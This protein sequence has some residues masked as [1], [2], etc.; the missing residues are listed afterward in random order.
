MSSFYQPK[1]IVAGY[2]LG[3]GVFGDSY[4]RVGFT[5]S[6][7]A[8]GTY[9]ITFNSSIDSVLYS[10]I[11]GLRNTAGYLSYN[12]ISTTGVNILTYTT[13]GVLTDF[14]F[15]FYILT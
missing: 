14:S 11:G 13:G 9:K 7:T 6:K 2:V 8:T 5:S 15:N 3:T 1:F 4:G 12:S 10:V